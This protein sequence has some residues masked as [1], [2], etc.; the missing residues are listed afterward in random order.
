MFLEKSRENDMAKPAKAA[1]MVLMPTM[2][3]A[4]EKVKPAPI[5]PRRN[6]SPSINRTLIRVLIRDEK[7]GNSHIDYRGIDSS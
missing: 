3:R 2:R 6:D 7:T 4:T 5:M 1:S